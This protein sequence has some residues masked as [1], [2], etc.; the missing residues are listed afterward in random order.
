V[1]LN[2]GS[3]PDMMVYD[4]GT[5]AYLPQGTIQATQALAA[6]EFPVWTDPVNGDLYYVLGWTAHR[7]N[8]ASNTWNH[9]I[10]FVGNY[11]GVAGVC[12]VDTTRRRALLLAG[13]PGG[14]VPTV[15]DMAAGAAANITMTGST[16]LSSSAGHFG[17]VF[18][19][20]TDRFYAMVGT[21]ANGADLYEV[22]PTTWAVSTKA[23]TGGTGMAVAE[24]GVDIHGVF[25]RIHYVAELGGILYFPQ[26]T[27]N[28]WF[29]RLH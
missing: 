23:T 24:N 3:A 19:P 29:L 6:A 12:C 26:Y 18:C 8:Q 11:Y 9:G 10:S 27:S 1:P 28:A 7:W 14:R 16:A 5:N 22:N 25:G 17:M 2:G 21:A 20:T 13:D 4:V 15:Y